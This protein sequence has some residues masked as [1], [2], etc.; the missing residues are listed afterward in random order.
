MKKRDNNTAKQRRFVRW[1]WGLILVPTVAIITII[2]L[3]AAGT[4]GRLP[5]FIELENPESNLA[6]EIY[7]A[8]GKVIGSFFIE[9]RSYVDYEELSP[10]LVAALVSTED[11]RF[12]THSG[13][14]FISLA[15]V[16]VKT[17][18]MG[19]SDQGGG[20]TITQQL[21][22]NLF[23]RDTTTYHSSIARASRLVL[24]KFKEWITAVKLEDNYTQEEILAMYFN[25]VFYGSNAY[26]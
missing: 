4:F 11:A 23:P 24:A 1:F 8:D 15:R 10:A 19:R 20:S 13:I 9:N 16:A 17:L 22:K 25:V 14:D 2:I 26:G 21:A 18:A 12:Y 7:S 6:T 5:S 3:T